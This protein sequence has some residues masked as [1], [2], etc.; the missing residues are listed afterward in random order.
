MKDHYSLLLSPGDSFL[1]YSRPK[2]VT[3]LILSRLAPRKRR[4]AFNT[5]LTTELASN[6]EQ[7]Q[8]SLKIYR[9]GSTIV[10]R[11]WT[12]PALHLPFPSHELVVF[13]D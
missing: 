13:V 11:A 9:V 10:H 1:S 8:C 4:T 2:P 7:Y 12:Y 6:E 5:T 3:L